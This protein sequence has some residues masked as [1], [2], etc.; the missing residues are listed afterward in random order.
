MNVARTNDPVPPEATKVIV[1]EERGLPL[2]TYWLELISSMLV[3]PEEI[4][5][6]LLDLHY[7]PPKTSERASEDILRWSSWLA[8]ALLKHETHI[9]IQIQ[10][11]LPEYDPRVI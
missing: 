2:G 9:D 10:R 8:D 7:C 6:W 4:R 1:F 11:R 5:E 3:V